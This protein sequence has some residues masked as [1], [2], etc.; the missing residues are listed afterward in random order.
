MLVFGIVLNLAGVGFFC[1]LLFELAVHALPFFVAVIT[2]F[3]AFHGG[4]GPIGAILIAFV[5]GV[6]TL[7]VGQMA[8]GM[9]RLPFIRATMAT[10]FAAPAV[11]AGYHVMLALSGLDASSA[12][13][14]EAFAS[15]DAILVGGTAWTR[16]TVLSP[17]DSG[18]GI[19]AGPARR[20]GMLTTRNQ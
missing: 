14:R 9:T 2:G 11:V 19:S 12:I 5:S 6:V 3:A 13:W 18:H 10:I 8:F 15:I 4:V 20:T 7:F 17:A 1:W 16:I